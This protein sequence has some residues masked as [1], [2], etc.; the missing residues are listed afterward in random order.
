MGSGTAYSYTKMQTEPRKI[1]I[2]GLGISGRAAAHLAI[3]RGAEVTV[4]DE[5]RN[6]ELTDWAVGL[7]SRGATVHLEWSDVQWQS[8]VDM[9]VISPG[10]APASSLGKLAES[11][12]C[13]VVSELEY[14]FRCASCPIIA[15]TGTNGKSTTVELMN[16]CLKQAGYRSVA[17]GNIGVALC[18]A[19][20]KYR[21]LDYLVV[22]VSSYQLEKIE[23]FKPLVAALL[24]LSPD[25]LDRY[26]TVKDYYAAKMLLFKNMTQRER[27]VLRADLARQ[28]LVKQSLPP[29]GHEPITFTSD[30]D[31]IEESKF[32]LSADGGIC[33]M[34]DGGR[35]KLCDAG[36]LRLRGRHNLEN[37]LAVLA[38]GYAGGLEIK[39]LL[40]GIRK[41]PPSPHRLE[42]VGVYDGVQFINDSKSTNPDSLT[43]ALEA[44]GEETQGKVILLAGGLD[45]GLDLGIVK[46]YIARYVRNVFLI[47]K[48]REKLA[49]LWGAAAPCQI[50][51]SLD[52]AFDAA[53]ESI[54][55]GDTVLLSPGCASQDMFKDY[56]DRGKCFSELIRRSYKQ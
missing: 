24:N 46:P 21:G 20:S 15:V 55:K 49:E 35:V 29:G 26:L 12:S 30:T 3:Q 11:L 52:N 31:T 41:F 32:Y 33:L 36:E 17:A 22:E 34:T 6:P 50:F 39:K 10:I 25:H 43:R 42:L 7:E 28:P 2:L 1:L 53:L 5:R 37:V 48:C 23:E 40:P 18:E 19:V 27:V 47:G 9:A 8:Q 51:A 54:E 44:I 13:P 4:L 45:K 38:M 56:A 14:G 16:Y